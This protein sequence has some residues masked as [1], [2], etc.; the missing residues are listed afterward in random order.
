MERWGE[1]ND[2]EV[3]AVGVEA[4]GATF[5]VDGGDFLVERRSPDE[6]SPGLA[7]PG[8]P[9]EDDPGPDGLFGGLLEHAHGCPPACCAVAQACA[10]RWRGVGSQA[11][12]PSQISERVYGAGAS[13]SLTKHAS[14]TALSAQIGRAH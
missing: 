3:V 4:H 2:V 8:G 1:L 6:P 13:A 14:Q 12:S 7:G 10:A 9:V 11:N 5:G